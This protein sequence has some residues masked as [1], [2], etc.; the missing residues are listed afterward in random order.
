MW[1][2]DALAKQGVERHV[3]SWKYTR[4]ENPFVFVFCSRYVWWININSVRSIYLSDHGISVQSKHNSKSFKVTELRQSWIGHV[5]NTVTY[6]KT[7]SDLD[8]ASHCTSESP[9]F[10]PR[11]PPH[12]VAEGDWYKLA[13]APAVH[14]HKWLYKYPSYPRRPTFHQ[15]R[16]RKKK[17]YF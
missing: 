15:L 6:A 11:S 8:K 5:S 2:S 13:T 4:E 14:P 9:Y 3:N 16:K 12:H 7:S 1:V 17:S 10:L